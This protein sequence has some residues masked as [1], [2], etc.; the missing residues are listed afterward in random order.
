[1]VQVDL[2]SGSLEDEY[3]NIIL[4]T[5]IFLLFLRKWFPTNW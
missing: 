5:G 4:E 3:E 2:E 1:M